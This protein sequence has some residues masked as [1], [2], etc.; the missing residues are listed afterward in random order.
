M[1]KSD[2]I[3]R[4]C[5][6]VF[7]NPKEVTKHLAAARCINAQAIHDASPAV[8]SGQHKCGFCPKMRCFTSEVSLDTHVK[9]CA[10][11]NRYVAKYWK[12][13]GWEP[14]SRYGRGLDFKDGEAA[15]KSERICQACY[16]CCK[17]LFGL[18]IHLE[19]GHCPGEPD[20]MG[21]EPPPP[22]SVEVLEHLARNRVVMP[23]H[24]PG[25][26]SKPLR[27]VEHEVSDTASAASLRRAGSIQSPAASSTIRPPTGDSRPQAVQSMP[28]ASKTPIVPICHE[29]PS[30]NIQ[31]SAKAEVS[32]PEINFLVE[33]I[34]TGPSRAITELLIELARSD[35]MSRAV[36]DAPLRPRKKRSHESDA[37]HAAEQ[38]KARKKDQNGG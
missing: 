7:A 38:A 36:P 20:E 33:V 12:E 31:K 6:K 8:R 26:I 11:R 5:K 10:P 2:R 27:T 34:N 13:A 30:S 37:D 22:P 15:A 28:L 19:K 29:M 35:P 16:Q 23:S 17:S 4:Y 3:C 32:T 24:R 25:A 1:V 14:G 18:T 9:L 21:W